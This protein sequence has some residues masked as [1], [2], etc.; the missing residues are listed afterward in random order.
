MFEPVNENISQAAETQENGKAGTAD[1]TL[2]TPYKTFEVQLECAGRVIRV[3]YQDLANY[4]LNLGDDVSETH[5]KL[6]AAFKRIK[7]VATVVVHKK[8]LVINLPLDVGATAFEKGFSR[9][10]TNIGHWGV[11][12]R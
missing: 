6:C 1:K 10:V 8:K 9:D 3:F 11:R 7:N 4:I 12:K 5:L 2:S